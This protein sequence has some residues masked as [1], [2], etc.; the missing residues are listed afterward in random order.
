MMPRLHVPVAW[1]FVAL[2]MGE[3]GAASG[4]EAF[5]PGNEAAVVKLLQPF[6]DEN[7]VLEGWSL[8]RLDIGPACELRLRFSSPDG[9]DL[10]TAT[11]RRSA[12][13]AKSFLFIWEPMRPPHLGDALEALVRGND[14][15]HFFRDRCRPADDLEE[16]SLPLDDAV[17]SLLRV[18]SHITR[19]EEEV[20]ELAV[21]IDSVRVWVPSAVQMFWLLLVLVAAA[22]LFLLGRGQRPQEGTVGGTRLR[23]QP[24]WIRVVFPAALLLR[25]VVAY[26]APTFYVEFKQF[27]GPLDVLDGTLSMPIFSDAVLFGD[28]MSYHLP[29]LDIGIG[30]WLALGD[31]LGMGGH[32]LWLRVPS[33]AGSAWVM[34]LLL[35]IGEHLG[36][37]KVGRVAMLLFAFLPACVKVSVPATHYFLEVVLVAWFIERLAAAVLAKRPCDRSL[38]V[39]GA[40]ACWS[41]MTVWP[42]VALG[43]LVYLVSRVR[44]GRARAGFLAMLVFLSLIAPMVNTAWNAVR[45]TDAQCVRG[46]FRKG[47]LAEG[48]WG[49]S[50]MFQP[51]GTDRPAI[52]EPFVFPWHMAIHLFNHL[53]TIIALVGIGVLFVLRDRVVPLTLAVLVAYA[54]ARMR[55]QL[56]HDNL[57][58]LFPLFLLLPPLGALRIEERFIGRRWLRYL[59]PGW[60][61]LTL[62]GGVLLPDIGEHIRVH[63]PDRVY[64]HQQ[65]RRL[66]FGENVRAVRRRLAAL[67]EDDV[68]LLSITESFAV[69]AARCGE[70]P[71]VESL[72]QCRIM[73]PV[74]GPG[75][76]VYQRPRNWGMDALLVERLSCEVVRDTLQGRIFGD[77]PVALLFGP[78]INEISCA[79]DVSPGGCSLLIDTP[80]LTLFLCEPSGQTVGAS[81]RGASR[82][83][84]Q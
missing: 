60:V 33:L 40:L 27:V 80:I 68:P 71:T 17:D 28:F 23:Q 38:A 78:D 47:D 56:S 74:D 35:R 73:D 69:Q 34:W 20:N 12:S 81:E 55:L 6:N 42:L 37:P 32:L 19:D 50:P 53:S 75:D 7:L 16:N 46:E 31:L 59:L 21:L 22:G 18:W 4:Q 79:R 58:F 3:A 48:L 76:L 1:F 61:A 67:A 51:L 24:V 44:S 57:A 8:E 45:K 66:L 77:R 84:S 65:A 39:A 9:D 29:L 49:V 10:V 36:A 63:E 54:M 30:P 25:L 72:K 43:G 64:Y 11:L 26:L 13:F 83:T 41:G 70:L 5:I 14:P 62:A 2:L 15:G 52:P 82:V